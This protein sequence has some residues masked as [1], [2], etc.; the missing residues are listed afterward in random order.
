MM[1]V[2]VVSF[3]V[4]RLLANKMT[5]IDV[6]LPSQVVLLGFLACIQ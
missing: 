4:R 2:A 3:Q 5:S 6:A 1:T